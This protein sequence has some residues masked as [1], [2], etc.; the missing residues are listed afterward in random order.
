MKHFDYIALGHITQDM[1]PNGPRLGGTATFAALTAR[2]LGCKTAI[3]TSYPEALSSMVDIVIRDIEI[4]R[5]PSDTAT[6]FRNIYTETGRTQYVST[7]AQTISHQHIPDFQSP[8]IHIAPIA[9]EVDMDVLKSF[10]GAFIGVTPQGFMRHWDETGLV[11]FKLR[12]AISRILTDAAAIVMSIEDVQGDEAVAERFASKARLLVITRSSEGSEVYI[13]GKATHIDA[14][15]VDEGDPTG[16]GDVFAAAFFIY[17]QKSGNPLASA[18]YA[19]VLAGHSV[20][21][22]GLSMLADDAMLAHALTEAEQ[23]AR[24]YHA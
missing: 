21:Y 1:T 5:I 3:V 20:K 10:P 18:R 12:P 15:S 11:S 6:T 13:S 19:S 2:A 24:E 4:H 14:I 8:L 22:P 23:A 9:N 17:L 16:A 7:P